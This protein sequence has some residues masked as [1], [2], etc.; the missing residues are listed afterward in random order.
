MD[1]RLECLLSIKK[2]CHSGHLAWNH[3]VSS[4]CRAASRL[5]WEEGILTV[6][7]VGS[8]NLD[9][10]LFE[11]PS[12]HTNHHYHHTSTF[13]K[14]CF[15]PDL[16]LSEAIPVALPPT[17]IAS[18]LTLR[19]M[20]CGTAWTLYLRSIFCT[21]TW[22]SRLHSATP[23]FLVVFGRSDVVAFAEC[24]SLIHDAWSL[25]GLHDEFL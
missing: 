4:P 11:F 6:P 24:V 13:R 8:T 15:G 18:S 23:G 3:A 10:Y 2:L 14:P 7:T 25:H 9:F 20:L 21:L 5:S 16:D 22:I 19:C 1:V 17:R 12:N